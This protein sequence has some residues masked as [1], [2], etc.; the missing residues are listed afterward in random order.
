M[1]ELPA[2]LVSHFG[3][4]LRRCTKLLF[5]H[6]LSRFGENCYTLVTRAQGEEQPD[7]A[8]PPDPDGWT[9]LSFFGRPTL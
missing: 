3:R 2:T 9:A 4:G 6:Q 8:A 7:I 1:S 5:H